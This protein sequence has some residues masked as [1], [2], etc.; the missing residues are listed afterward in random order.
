MPR[1]VASCGSLQLP[2]HRGSQLCQILILGFIADRGIGLRMNI[3]RTIVVFELLIDL[4]YARDLLAVA[5]PGLLSRHLTHS[6]VDAYRRS[7]PQAPSK[8]WRWLDEF[9]DRATNPLR[10]YV[11][12]L[13]LGASWGLPFLCLGLS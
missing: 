12:V 7:L 6:V 8:H 2:R 10:R 3:I 5:T 4:V 13:K 11:S 1:P 9:F